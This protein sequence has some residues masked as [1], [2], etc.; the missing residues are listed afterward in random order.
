M[1]N[2]YLTICTSII[3]IILV[4]IF[5]AK[6][7]ND[8]KETQIFTKMLVV[9]VLESIVTTAIIIA[10][11]VSNSTN[12]FRILNVMDIILIVSWCSL[13]FYYVHTISTCDD[14]KKM[15]PFILVVNAIFYVLAL[16]LDVNIIKENDIISSCGPLIDFGLFGILFYIA[17]I[18]GTLFLYSKKNN[19]AKDKYISLYSL[20]ILLLLSVCLKIIIYP[21]NVIPIVLTIVNMIMMFTIENPDAKLIDQL[22]V[23]KE[24]AEQANLAKSDFL[25][26]M[27]HEIRTPLNA[28]VGF[29]QSLHEKKLPPDAK[30]EVTDI[31]TASQNLLEIVNGI[32]DFSKI[33]ANKLEII[34]KNYDVLEMLNEVKTLINVR[35]GDKKLELHCYFDSTLPKAL[36]GDVTRIR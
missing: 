9:N 25:S 6:K 13:L 7:K 3:S 11:L 15:V 10:S 31:V 33:E 32:L 30:E 19:L 27:S 26:N 34:N 21:I 29:S 24:K 18:L 22:T 14:N 28:I 36:Y 1:T 20:I 17:L 8:Y 4:I 5:F 23:A 2:G 16:F 12:L 35:I